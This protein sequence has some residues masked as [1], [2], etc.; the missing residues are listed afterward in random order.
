MIG[1]VTMHMHSGVAT[2]GSRGQSSTPDSENFIKNRG[3]RQVEMRKNREEKSLN[4]SS[5]DLTF[6][7]DHPCQILNRLFYS[8]K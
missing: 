5:I 4:S 6:Y 2:G 3:K 1:H 8:S 7:R